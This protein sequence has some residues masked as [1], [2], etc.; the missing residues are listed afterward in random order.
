MEHWMQVQDTQGYSILAIPPSLFQLGPSVGLHWPGTL[1]A[2]CLTPSQALLPV[3]SCSLATQFHVGFFQPRGEKN[4]FAPS[5]YTIFMAK[6]ASPSTPRAHGA[7]QALLGVPCRELSPTELQET[8]LEGRT[9]V[10]LPGHGQQRLPLLPGHWIFGWGH[11]NPGG[12]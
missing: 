1:H 5:K 10:L 12:S 11:P 7:L 6:A 2:G 3:P 4:H 8:P 9:P